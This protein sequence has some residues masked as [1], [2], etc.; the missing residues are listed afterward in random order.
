MAIEKK[1]CIRGNDCRYCNR[2]GGLT[3]GVTVGLAGGLNAKPHTAWP[4]VGPGSGRRHLQLRGLAREIP[5]GNLADEFKSFP[6]FLN[7]RNPSFLQNDIGRKIFLPETP[8]R[9]CL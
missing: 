5:V 7:D 4:E 8:L 9:L 2:A 1:K 6:A 3:C